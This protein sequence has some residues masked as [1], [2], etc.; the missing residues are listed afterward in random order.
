MPTQDTGV[1]Y[2]RTVAVANISFTAMTALQSAVSRAILEDPAVDGLNSYIGTNNG[3]VLSNGEMLVAL[4]PPAVR[5][6][7]IQQV[8]ARLR[9]TRGASRRCAGLLHAIPGSGTRCAEQRVALSVH[10]HRQRSRATLP[11]GPTGCGARWL[12]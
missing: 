2:V 9:G 3:S 10:A 6:L 7:T 8:I 4:K 5:K 12:T 11:N 1:I